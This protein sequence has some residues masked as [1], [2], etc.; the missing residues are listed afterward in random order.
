VIES[1]GGVVA[2]TNVS[3]VVPPQPGSVL[4]VTLAVTNVTAPPS[5]TPLRSIVLNAQSSGGVMS[6]LTD[7]M[8]MTLTYDADDLSGVNT[9]HLYVRAAVVRGVAGSWE[10]VPV[11]VNRVLRTVTAYVTRLGEYVLVAEPASQVYVPIVVR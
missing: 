8:T 9:A 7:A 11:V 3:V 10:A 5:G 1:L 4:T 2:T 6:E